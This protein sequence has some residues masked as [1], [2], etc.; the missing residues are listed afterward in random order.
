MKGFIGVLLIVLII[1]ISGCTQTGELID[2]GEENLTPEEELILEEFLDKT[3]ETQNETNITENV[4]PSA[5]YTG[6]TGPQNITQPPGCPETCDDGDNCTYDYCSGDTG[7]ECVH[8]VRICPN[9]VKICPDGVEVICKNICIDDLCTTCR[10]DCS[11]YQLPVCEMTQDDCTP[12]YILDTENCECA[13]IISCGINNDN[14]CPGECNYTSDNDCEEPECNESW[15]CSE[16]SEC[17]NETQNMVCT[18]ANLCN[19]TE[20]VEIRE[21]QEEPEVFNITI[22]YVNYTE[23]WVEIG[24]FGN[25]EVDMTNWTINDTLTSPRE[26]FRFPEFIL[27]PGNYVYILKGYGENNAT[28]LY[29]N[30]NDYVWNDKGDTAVLIDNSGQIISQYSYE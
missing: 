7:Y 14:C 21:C 2:A 17:I 12:C 29:R 15:E 5:V 1:L 18:D 25:T 20:R 22:T 30:K 3:P 8:A 23:E 10:P 6:H 13:Q 4:P 26:V 27:Q 16:W 11:E 24:N 28:H 9:F 19:T